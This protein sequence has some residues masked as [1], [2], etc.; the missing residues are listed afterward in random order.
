MASQSN[1]PAAADSGLK[2]D[3]ALGGDG[4]G[5]RELAAG[6][7]L[8]SSSLVP[9]RC[10]VHLLP[11]AKATD[12]GIVYRRG[13]E[14]FLLAWPRIRAAFAAEVGEPEGVRTLVFDLALEPSGPECVLCRFD[15]EPGDEAQ[16]LARA[17]EVGVGREQCSAS[18]RSLAREGS[19][20]RHYADLETL[21][22][23]HLEAVRF[24]A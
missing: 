22:E 15:V 11:D 18:L 4:F 24:R 6:G 7:A 3:P 9:S 12:R 2:D 17:I 8:A 21:T 16:A 19:P 23:A 13:E 5:V 10:R 20:T 1:V 14:R